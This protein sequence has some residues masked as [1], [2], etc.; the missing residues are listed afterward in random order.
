MVEGDCHVTLWFNGFW[1]VGDCADFAAK[2]T[3]DSL[4][5]TTA[6]SWTEFSGPSFWSALGGL[7][8][9]VWSA[10]DL[11]QSFPT[12]EQGGNLG[13]DY[14]RDSRRLR[15]RCSDGRRHKRARSPFGCDF[16]KATRI[17]VSDA[18]GE[19][20]LQR[21]MLWPTS[22]VCPYGSPSH[23]VNSMTR[24][25]PAICWVICTLDKCC[26]PIR[27]MT[28]TGSALWSMAKVPGPTSRRGPIARIQSVSAPCSTEV[29]TLLRGSLTNSNASGVLQRTMINSATN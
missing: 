12:P 29:A 13:S 23:P 11:L 3:R 20:L 16:K 18:A 15:W 28:P 25:S 26:L 8:G 6:G 7:A 4:C 1:M 27:L 21:S 17:V 22:M 10:Y 2:V 14:G 19:V 9:S 24:P 5:R